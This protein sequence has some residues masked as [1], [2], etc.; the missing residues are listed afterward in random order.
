LNH[1]EELWQLSKGKGL[2]CQQP[3]P[4]VDMNSMAESTF[5]LII[6][7]NGKVRGTT[8]AQKG[9]NQADAEKLAS[10]LPDVKKWL[11]S[12]PKRVIFVVDRLINF[13]V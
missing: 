2:A 12:A 8:E 9:I 5:E 11:T 6:Q 3:W 7:V 1:V 10:E 4:T 13:I